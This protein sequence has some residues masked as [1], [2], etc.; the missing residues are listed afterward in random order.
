MKSTLQ[1]CTIIA[2]LTFTPTVEAQRPG[3]GGRGGLGGGPG[4]G[5]GGRQDGPPPG[6]NQNN[7][8]L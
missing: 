8:N 5:G 2:L 3:G 4:G 6:M 7:A 1:I